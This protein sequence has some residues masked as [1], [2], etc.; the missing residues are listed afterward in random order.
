M[1]LSSIGSNATEEFFE[2]ILYGTAYAE[3]QDALRGVTED[4][5]NDLLQDAISGASSIMIAGAMSVLIRKQEDLISSIFE[6][7][8]SYIL[9][10]LGSEFITKFKNRLRSFKGAK[11]FRRL[12]LFSQS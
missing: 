1:S 9:A 12:G 5:D 6:T 11:L 10:I 4:V 8:S 2:T 7:T 3:A